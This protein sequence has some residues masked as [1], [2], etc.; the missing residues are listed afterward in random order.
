[1]SVAD[2][3]HTLT[4]PLATMMRLVA[5]SRRWNRLE[6]PGWKPPEDH[7]AVYPRSSISVATS[8]EASS[9]RQEPL[10]Q[11]PTGPRSIGGQRIDGA[12]SRRGPERVAEVDM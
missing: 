6:R 5:P 4:I 7:R 12:S 11:M 8:T 2:P 3:T 9:A 1:M 10:H